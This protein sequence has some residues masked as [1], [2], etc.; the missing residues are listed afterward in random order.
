MS[1]SYDS[2]D[3]EWDLEKEENIAMLLAMHANKRPF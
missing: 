2:S 1:S 3:E